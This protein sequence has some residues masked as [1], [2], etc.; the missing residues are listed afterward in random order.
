[1]RDNFQNGH[2]NLRH[3]IRLTE[4]ERPNFDRT[5]NLTIEFPLGI[6]ADTQS[7]LTE[8]VQCCSRLH[9]E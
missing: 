5:T 7:H 1:M 4:A 6:G 3:S 8:V 2:K 9:S